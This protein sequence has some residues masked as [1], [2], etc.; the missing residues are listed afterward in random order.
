M[1]TWN[2][3]TN[4]TLTKLVNQSNIRHFLNLFTNKT[5]TVAASQSTQME[6]SYPYSSAYMD[7]VAISEL[8][9][10]IEQLTGT[11]QYLVKGILQSVRGSQY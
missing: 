8:H 3:N 10:R 6:G 11:L 7:C 4:S 1:G 2:Y 9:I 5:I